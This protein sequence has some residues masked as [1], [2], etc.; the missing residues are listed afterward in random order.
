LPSTE[1][2]ETFLITP[3]N[4]SVFSY[5]KLE[6]ARNRNPGSNRKIRDRQRVSY[7]PTAP[8]EMTIQ[9]CVPKALRGETIEVTDPKRAFPIASHSL[10]AMVRYS[11]IV[12]A[13]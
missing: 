1:L 8:L 7:E 11:W 2:S 6:R 9:Y 3:E 4:L 5:W 13:A 12:T 10:P